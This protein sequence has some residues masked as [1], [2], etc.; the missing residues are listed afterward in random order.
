VHFVIERNDRED[1]EKKIILPPAAPS[2]ISP[3]AHAPD[4]CPCLRV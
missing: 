2:P 1:F 3:F 4:P